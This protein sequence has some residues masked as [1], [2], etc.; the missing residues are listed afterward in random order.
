MSMSES[1]WEALHQ[2]NPTVP[3]GDLIKEEWFRFYTVDPKDPNH[4]LPPDIDQW[5]QSWDPAISDKKTADYWVGQ[6]WA[7]KG[8][9]I[10]L[11]KQVRGH[12]SLAEAL[13]LIRTL[14]AQ[15]PKALAKLMENSAM[16]PAIKQTLQH[17]IPGIIPINAIGSK[18]S[19]VEAITPVLM[20]NN[21]Y[22][23]ENPNGTKPQ[24]VRELIQECTSFPKGVNDDQVDTMTQAINFMTPAGWTSLRRA[25]ESEKASKVITPLEAQRTRFH[26]YT[27]HVLDKASRRFRP[28]H[29]RRSW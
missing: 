22:L 3:G 6:V 24:W 9:D 2:G 25:A 21:I 8:A 28:N 7:R 17:E 11:V 1:W 5:L 10:Y 15:Y 4:G 19:R 27:Q 29:S 26:Q 13:G 23:P 12:Y 20:A 14:Q 18:R 16:G